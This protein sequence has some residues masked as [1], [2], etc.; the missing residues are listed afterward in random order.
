MMTMAA[1]LRVLAI[2]VATGRIGCVL[3]IGGEL[4]DWRLSRTA[5][6]SAKVARAQAEKWIDVLRPDVVVTEAVPKRS[7]K[8][9][10]TRQLIDA[11]AAVAGEKEL[12]DVKVVRTSLFENKYEEAKALGQRFPEIAAWVPKKRRIWEPEPRNT[13]YFEALALAMQVMSRPDGAPS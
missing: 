11:I 10:K 12:L 1:R 9:T 13:I 5:A 8:S 2:A 6:R 3:L 4:R 7:S